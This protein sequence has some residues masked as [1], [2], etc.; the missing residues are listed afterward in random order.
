MPRVPTR[1]PATTVW[2]VGHSNHSA[3]DFVAILQAHGIEL[4][5]D[6][7]RFRA[8]RR[9]PHFGEAALAGRLAQAGIGYAGLEFLGGR[10]HVPTGEPQQGWRNTSFRAYAAYTW[11][12]EFAEGLAQLQDLAE[13][14]RT[15][16]MCSEVLWWRCHRALV[17]DVL[18][19]LGYEVLHIPGRGAASAHPYTSPARVVDGELAYPAEGGVPLQQR[20]RAGCC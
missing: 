2:T 18:C 6:V 13:A 4:V 7:R 11:T 5:A 15:A 17:A 8:S 9:H 3:E 12:P 14:Q 16:M 1:R 19:F 10:R 20:L